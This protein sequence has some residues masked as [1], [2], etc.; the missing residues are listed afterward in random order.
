MLFLS[1]IWGALQKRLVLL[2]LLLH[3]EELQTGGK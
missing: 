1:N 2:I 3:I